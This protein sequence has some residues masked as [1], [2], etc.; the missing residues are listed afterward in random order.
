MASKLISKTI[1][2]PPNFCLKR[3]LFEKQN[4]KWTT[5]LPVK[6]EKNNKLEA[7][8]KNIIIKV[9]AHSLNFQERN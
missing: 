9:V 4:F 6:K 3:L 1:I 5:D 2:Y 7:H 8:N